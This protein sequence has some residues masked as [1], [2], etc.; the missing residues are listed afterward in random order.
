MQVLVTLVVVLL[1]AMV[2]MSLVVT[3]PL[4]QAIGDAVGVGDAAVTAWDIAKWPVL[5]LL[6][7]L[8]FSL[9]YYATPNVKQ[10]KFTWSTA[11][12]IWRWSSGS[13]LQPRSPSTWPTS[14]PT[15]RPTA[16][17]AVII[18]LVWLWL[19]NVAVLFGAEFNAELNAVVS[20]RRGWQEAE[21][22]ILL[23]P[24]QQKKAKD[25]P[26]VGEKTK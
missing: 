20:C 12:G 6:V 4:A 14:A 9:L 26:D 25:K 3:G 23:P 21:E 16:L 17:A 18:F 13:S 7:S 1:L 19:S 11:G 22:T 24:R 15:T 5:A 2:A 10:P 8:I